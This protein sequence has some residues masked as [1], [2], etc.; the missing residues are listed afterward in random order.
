MKRVWTI[1]GFG[2]LGA[3]VLYTG[4]TVAQDE[5]TQCV[6]PDEWRLRQDFMNDA[7]IHTRNLVAGRNAVARR[8]GL[9]ER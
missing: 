6:T 3:C 2:V 4:Y 7:D 8:F 5:V 1:L 9:E